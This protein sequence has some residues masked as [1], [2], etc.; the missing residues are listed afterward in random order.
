[1]DIKE[2]LYSEFKDHIEDYAIEGLKFLQ[3]N[4]AFPE[5]FNYEFALVSKRRGLEDKLMEASTKDGVRRV[6][7]YETR[8]MQIDDE[9]VIRA[10]ELRNGEGD[11]QRFCKAMKDMEKQ[12]PEMKFEWIPYRS[13]N[14]Y[15][16]D[17]SLR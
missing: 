11:M 13:D 1:M 2:V 16:K 10:L 7:L 6:T 3:A 17:E 15:K 5:V 12:N 8:M 14:H 4:A 9:G